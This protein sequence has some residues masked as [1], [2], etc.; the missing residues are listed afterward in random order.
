MLQGRQVGIQLT[1]QI[2]LFTYEGFLLSRPIN[3]GTESGKE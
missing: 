3:G 2:A 1:E